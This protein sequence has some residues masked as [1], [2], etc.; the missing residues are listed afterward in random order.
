MNA[1]VRQV[2]RYDPRF[3]VAQP[4]LEAGHRSVQQCRQRLRANVRGDGDPA[5]TRRQRLVSLP[6]HLQDHVRHRHSLLPVRP[7]DVHHHG[8]VL[9]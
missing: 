1:H 8:T 5:V 9:L 3:T 4:R 2:Q 7:T 6:G